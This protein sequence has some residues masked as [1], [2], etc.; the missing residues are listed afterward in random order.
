MK[1]FLR[2][3]RED[4][5]VF[6]YNIC[7]Q[8]KSTDLSQARV[9]LRHQYTGHQQKFSYHIHGET[10]DLM[11][12]LVK[13]PDGDRRFDLTDLLLEDRSDLIEIAFSDHFDNLS[14]VFKDLYRHFILSDD[15][16][17]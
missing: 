1:P 13:G 10:L 16:H 14:K 8:D 7:C 17:L 9:L 5:V 11:Y 4:K 6:E 2:N 15:E 12:C 3:Q